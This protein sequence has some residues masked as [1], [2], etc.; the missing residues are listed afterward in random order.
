MAICINIKNFGGREL[1][2]GIVRNY[3]GKISL[4]KKP[5][6]AISSF[7][8]RPMTERRTLKQGKRIIRTC[9]V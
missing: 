6:K 4:T 2:E 3:Y 8:K 5:Q 7:A 1:V 9:T